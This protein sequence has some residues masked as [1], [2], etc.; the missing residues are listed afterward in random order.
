MGIR[1][2]QLFRGRAGQAACQHIPIARSFSAFITVR[3]VK[4]TLEPHSAIIKIRNRD[5]VKYSFIWY[6]FSMYVITVG[7]T[8]GLGRA[9]WKQLVIIRIWNILRVDASI[10]RVHQQGA[11]KKNTKIMK[12]WANPV[13]A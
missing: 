5:R 1:Q 3:S 12:Q 10:V 9:F 11:A 6:W 13:E 2:S 7:V 4:N 8:K